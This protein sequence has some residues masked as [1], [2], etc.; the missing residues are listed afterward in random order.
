MWMN[1]RIKHTIAISTP[2]V[3]TLSDYISVLVFKGILVMAWN[4]MV[5]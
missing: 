1:V 2:G 5:W 3:T 4:A